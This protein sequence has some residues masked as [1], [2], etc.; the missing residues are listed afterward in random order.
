MQHVLY[1]SHIIERPVRGT[2]TEVIGQLK[3]LVVQMTGE[4]FP[5]VT[6]LVVAV[7]GR[8]GHRCF[9]ASEYVLDLAPNAIRLSTSMIDLHP[10]ARRT[11]EALLQ[12]DVLDKQVVDINGRRVIRVNDVTLTKVDRGWVLAGADVSTAALLDRLGTHALAARMSHE[13]IPW[14][15]LQFFASEV[16]GT[17]IQLTYD[18][19]ARLHPMDIADLINELGYLQ[20]SEVISALDESLAAHIVEG[21]S[22]ERQTAVFGAMGVENAADILGEMAPDEAADLLLELP[23]AQAEELL[24]AMEAPA[25]A[26]VKGLLDYPEDTAGGMMTTE[27]VAV[28]QTLTVKQVIDRLRSYAWLPNIIYYIYVVESEEQGRLLGVISLRDLLM[29]DTDT[30]ITDLMQRDIATGHVYDAA[31]DV[32]RVIAHYNLLAL[33]IIDTHGALAGIV[34]V[35]DA[36]DIILPQN[37]KNRLPRIFT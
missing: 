34:T 19:L 35:D 32:A 15:A 1:L 37:W 20:G 16:P 8:R 7:P 14:D 25:A 21:F 3:D 6:G 2:S 13:V 29:A 31:E 24:E 33:P 26:E 12:K 11:G 22:L 36:M 28:P 27:Y 18:K 17:H 9:I 10:F 5:L 23:E 4:P 30:A